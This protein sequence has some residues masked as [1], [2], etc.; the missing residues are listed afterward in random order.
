MSKKTL[1]RMISE[2]KGGNRP[3]RYTVIAGKLTAAEMCSMAWS[4][5]VDND[6]INDFIR[7]NR[8]L[9]G[10]A[11]VYAASTIA[12]ALGGAWKCSLDPILTASCAASYS[13]FQNTKRAASTAKRNLEEAVE[14]AETAF[15][16]TNPV[17]NDATIPDYEK[18]CKA[19]EADL[20]N[21]MQTDEIKALRKASIDASAALDAEKEEYTKAC[22]SVDAGYR[23]ALA[24]RRASMAW[25]E[26]DKPDVEIQ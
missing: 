8:P 2:N 25:K 19:W 17:P 16:A 4:A 14:A 6:E 11:A 9:D 12:V 1:I 7:G 23:T 3:A 10:V 18:V 13:A 26:A 21:A 20:W 15:K 22:L 24:L 5:E